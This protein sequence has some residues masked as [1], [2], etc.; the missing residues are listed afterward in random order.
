MFIWSWWHYTRCSILVHYLVMI[1]SAFDYYWQCH[2]NLLLL[3]QVFLLL[4]PH[5]IPL[6]EIKLESE[7]VIEYY[8]LLLLTFV[9]FSPG[10]READFCILTNTCRKW[11]THPSIAVLD[12]ILTVIFWSSFHLNTVVISCG[13]LLLWS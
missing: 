5:C 4:M 3:C 1:H 10:N 7:A 13:K 6:S 11:G 2:G 12:W 8:I 9:L